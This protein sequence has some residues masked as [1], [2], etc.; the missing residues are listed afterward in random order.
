MKGIDFLF[1]ET[2]VEG[3]RGSEKFF[4]PDITDSSSAMNY[5]KLTAV[6]AG[7]ITLKQYLKDQ[8]IIPT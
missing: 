4:N 3:A 8:K 2:K 1:C 7:S 5:A 6:M